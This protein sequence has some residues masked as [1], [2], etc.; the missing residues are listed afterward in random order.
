MDFGAEIKA[1]LNIKDAK[2]TF[3]L[4]KKSVQNETIKIKLGV[5]QSTFNTSSITKQIQSV[6]TNAGTTA[7]KSYGTALQTQI[8]TIAKTQRNAFSQPLNNMNKQQ[9]S[10]IDWWQNQLVTY[11]KRVNSVSSK[12]SDKSMDLSIAKISSKYNSYKDIGYSTK[13]LDKEYYK[14]QKLQ[15][16]ITEL[17]SRVEKGT[18]TEKEKDAMVRYYGQLE[19][20]MKKTK[21]EIGILNEQ[22]GKPITAEKAWT[23]SNEV[24]NYLNKNTKAAKQYGNQ[25]KQLSESF[26][27]VKT[28]GEFDTLNNQ[29][30]NLKSEIN[31]KGLAGNSI[32][33]ELGRGF[34]QIG[35]FAMTYGGIQKVVRS[36]VDSVNQLKEVDSIITEIS[37]TSDLT[38][39]QLKELANNSF[40]AASKYGKTATDYLTGIQEMSRSGFYG[41]K[42]EGLA[43]LSILGQAAGDMSADV[44]N[45]YLLATNAAY[46]Y[47]GSVEKL[48]AVLDGQNMIT[49]RNSVSMNDMA[50]ATSKAASMASQT[51]VQVDE[52]S[53]IIGTAVSRTKQDGNEIGTALK[54]LFVNLQDTSN[55]KIVSTFDA[56]GI[57]QTKLVNGS[58]QLK[59]PIELLKELADAYNNLEEGSALKAD[60]L[61]NI[62]NKRQANVLAAILSG[63]SSGDYDKMIQDYSQGTGSAAE[64]AAKSAN[65]WEG[66]LNRLSNAWIELMS[67][68]ANSDAITGAVNA[69]ASLVNGVDDLIGTLGAIPTV[70]G[71]AGAFFGMKNAGKLYFAV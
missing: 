34:K 42:A 26:K 3:D 30:K 37:K 65:N 70:G 48:N 24:Q 28:Q 71:L 7:G 40:D 45:S 9:Q 19:S 31:L 39:S 44:S 49:N 11:E 17:N 63:I 12:V 16:A 55:K 41:K 69:L 21:N 67:N 50:E 35:Q 62:G 38:N 29:Y 56:L 68:F 57:S 32:I 64:E 43:E 23:K 53:A 46:E 15:G 13:S 1:T 10:Y 18:A 61:R 36:I 5:D 8:N 33:S 2:D 4:F 58:K 52:L 20:S 22:Y 27:A 59:T 25:L 54:S 14:I 51:G 60:V 47:Q 6:Y 66:S